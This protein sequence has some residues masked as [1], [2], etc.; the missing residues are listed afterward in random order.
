M[1]GSSTIIRPAKRQRTEKRYSRA[2]QSFLDLCIAGNSHGI[3][4]IANF[5]TNLRSV[6]TL[7]FK[8]DSK[9]VVLANPGRTDNVKFRPIQY[10]ASL[11]SSQSRVRHMVKK[12]WIEEGGDTKIKS[13]FTHDNDSSQFQFI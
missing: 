3:N 2:H 12:L 10:D 8:R 6:F 4:C 13:F 11:M 9:L 1:S 7:L 5:M